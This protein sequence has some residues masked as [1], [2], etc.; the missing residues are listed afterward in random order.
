MNPYDD[1]LDLP[2]H[3]SLRH[4][5]MSMWKRAAQFAPFA[6]LSGHG[7]AIAEVARLTDTEWGG[8]ESNLSEMDRTLSILATEIA[9]RPTVEVHYYQPDK[10]KEGGAYLTHRAPLK[11]IDTIERTLV[12][13]DGCTIELDHIVNLR[14]VNNTPSGK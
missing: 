13:A 12:F 4:K 9:L 3:V 2:H 7:D 1:L 10:R 5:P 11:A 6:A 8:D 14:L